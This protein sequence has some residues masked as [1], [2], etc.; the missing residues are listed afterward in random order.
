[1]ACTAVS[2]DLVGIPAS[3]Y[4]GQSV[5]GLANLNVAERIDPLTSC[6]FAIAETGL[7]VLTKVVRDHSRVLVKLDRRADL[8]IRDVIPPVSELLADDLGDARVGEIDPISRSDCISNG[9]YMGQLP[10][11]C[12]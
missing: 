10:V 8:T 1:M 11:N 7:F 2:H 3:R 5:D 6:G 12:L 9:R 4:V